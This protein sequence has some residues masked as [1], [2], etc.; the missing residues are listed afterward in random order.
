MVLQTIPATVRAP[1]FVGNGEIDIVEQRVPEPGVGQLLIEVKANALCASERSQF[2][3]G[4]S[5]TPGHEAA[6][7]VAAAGPGT[8]VAV[9]T[10]GVVYLM[11][12]CGACRS[13]RSGDTNQCLQKRGDMGFTKNGG[14]GAY[15]LDF[16]VRP[17]TV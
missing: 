6:G 15:E 12:F 9:G 11:D 10:P 13:C 16:G 8:R 1:H 17:L 14:Y 4:S 2:M 3:T 7:V 5:V